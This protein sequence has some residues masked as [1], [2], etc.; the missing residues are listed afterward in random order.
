MHGET[1][2]FVSDV[3]VVFN[4]VQGYRCYETQDRWRK[5]L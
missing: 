2:T 4:T 1:V 5:G 3:T